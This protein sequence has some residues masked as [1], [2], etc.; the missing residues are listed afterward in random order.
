[1]TTAIK[2]SNLYKRYK[3]QDGSF[4][5]AVDNLSFAADQGEIIALLGPNG[6]GKTTTVKMIGGLVLPDSGSVEI[7]GFDNQKQKLKA[8]AGCAAVLEGA[9]NI[10]WRLSVNENIEYFARL[11]GMNLAD[12]KERRDYLLELLELTENRNEAVRNLSRGNQQKVAIACAMI[13]NTPVLLLDEPTL[14]LDIEISSRL[15]T[16]L[17]GFARQEKKLMIITTHDMKLVEETADR[18]IIVNHGK[19]ITDDKV[20]NLQNLFRSIAYKISFEQSVPENCFAELN[21]LNGMLTLEKCDHSG[22]DFTLNDFNTLY[23]V[24]EILNRHQQN[25]I[26]IETENL[27]FEKIFLNLLQKS[28]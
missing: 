4:V 16:A 10:Y 23:S 1:M 8:L 26:N 22:L 27:D 5:Q 25:I 20:K 28:K 2:L 9:R 12:V 21:A 11:R 24:M 17:T 18:V 7:C 15:R 6:A 13:G 3:K 19:V 14:G